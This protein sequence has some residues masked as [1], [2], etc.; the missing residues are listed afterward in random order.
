MRIGEDMMAGVCTITNDVI[1]PYCTS[2]LVAKVT[3]QE[4]VNFIT[5]SP[6]V[7]HLDLTEKV[8]EDIVCYDGSQFCCHRDRFLS[9]ESA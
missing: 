9:F 1:T 8:A 7:S 2:V 3:F 6:Y 4:S 5:F